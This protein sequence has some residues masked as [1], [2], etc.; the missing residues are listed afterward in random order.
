[1]S[2]L[3]GPIT[4]YGKTWANPADDFNRASV[5]GF[6]ELF[7]I[8]E[9][10]L[11]VKFS[12]EIGQRRS[13]ASLAALAEYLTKQDLLVEGVCQPKIM[14][15][16]AKALGLTTAAVTDVTAG[17]PDYK[18]AS[19]GG[20][21]ALNYLNIV[22]RQ[23]MANESSLYLYVY[24][25]KAH[26]K[27]NG[28]LNLAM[29]KHAT[30]PFQIRPITIDSGTHVGKLFDVAM[31]YSTSTPVITSVTGG[32]TT[33]VGD[34]VTIAGSGFGSSRGTSTATFYNAKVGVTYPVWT[35]NAIVVKVPA[36]AA[37]GAVKVTVAGVDSNT[38]KTITIT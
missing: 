36:D 22:L 12:E 18:K 15:D 30:I 29:D 1:M 28:D 25:Y 16:I 3:V 27:I 17:D 31:D 6:T 21:R 10:A 11:A 23:Q 13:A 19:F 32:T 26:I 4:V 5:S 7:T 9:G 14:D 35:D 20:M 24:I 38:D 33:N 34:L 8:E 37:T 2:D